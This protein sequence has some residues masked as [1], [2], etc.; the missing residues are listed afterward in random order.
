M[1]HYT[2]G[3]VGRWFGLV[4]GAFAVAAP[5][6]GMLPEKVAAWVQVAGAAILAGNGALVK[7]GHKDGE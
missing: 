7:A 6:I 4:A 1:A 5:Y 3:K 2:A